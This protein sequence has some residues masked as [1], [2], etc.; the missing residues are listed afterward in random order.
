MFILTRLFCFLNAILCLNFWQA[1]QITSL[2][3]NNIKDGNITSGSF[4]TLECQME[5]QVQCNAMWETS[6]SSLSALHPL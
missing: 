4:I 5:G 2:A 6:F 3:R 1:D